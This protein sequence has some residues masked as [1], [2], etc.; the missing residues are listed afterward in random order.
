VRD[1]SPAWPL[2]LL[3]LISAC[4]VMMP[5]KPPPPG[6]P[7]AQRLLAGPFAV[8]TRDVTFVDPAPP[9]VDAPR[10]LV[11][12]VWFP[13]DAQG[14]HP[15]VVYSH[16]FEANR[17]GG[18]YLAEHLASHGYVVAAPDHPGTHR[19]LLGSAAIEDVLHQPRDLQVVVDHV[20]SWG[21][22]ERPFAGD[23]D[24]ARI[25]VMG[26]SLGGMTATMDAF[27]P[28]LRDPRVRAAVS[29]AGPMILF[30]PGYFRNAHVPFLMVAGGADV[31]VDYPANAHLALWYVPDSTLVGIG[32]ASHA[33]FDDTFGGPLRVLANPDRLAC[34][35]LDRDLDMS[36][37]LKTLTAMSA[38]GAGLVVPASPLRPC[39][40]APP[41]RALDPARQ[42]EVT[43][44][45]VG[46]FFDSVFAPAVAAREAA[47]AYL[48][49]DLARDFPEVRVD[50]APG[51]TS[52]P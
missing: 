27:D 13:R 31:I 51:A 29:I 48:R 17:F 1:P 32:G 5:A 10:T 39:D 33:G 11:T 35:W 50:V 26:L 25:G 3:V 41:C 49:H 21:P 22:A 52:T 45:A 20:L 4:A 9:G 46:A 43:A 18:T 19:Q 6:S 16:G 34:W 44:A 42:Q 24:A 15:L 37:G 14:S 38:A 30:A 28:R 47:A 8:A 23:I 12:T 7:S 40:T 36:Q 2:A